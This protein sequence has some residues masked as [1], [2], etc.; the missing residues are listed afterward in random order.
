MS[1]LAL[2][3]KDKTI[4]KETGVTYCSVNKQ[5]FEFQTMSISYI[6]HTH[7]MI[8]GVVMSNIILQVVSYDENLYRA[9]IF[10]KHLL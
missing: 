4:F 10:K 9:L 7:I 2:Y 1:A 3:I 5:I 6:F 8:F